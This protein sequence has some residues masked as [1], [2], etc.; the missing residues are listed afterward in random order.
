MY[1]DIRLDDSST[2]EVHLMNSRLSN[3]AATCF[4][5]ENTVLLLVYTDCTTTGNSSLHEWKEKVCDA[6][7]TQTGKICHLT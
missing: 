4:F 5:V 1:L 2:V 6:C 7:S 3:G